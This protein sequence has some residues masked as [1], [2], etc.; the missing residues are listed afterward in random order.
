[1]VP[2]ATSFMVF[3]QIAS[4]SSWPPSF[5]IIRTLPRTEDLLEGAVLRSSAKVMRAGTWYSSKK[6]DSKALP[7]IGIPVKHNKGTLVSSMEYRWP[8][9]SIKAVLGLRP[10]IFAQ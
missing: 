2:F 4:A 6:G 1:M 7:T 9:A 8:S 3:F 10:S 5:P